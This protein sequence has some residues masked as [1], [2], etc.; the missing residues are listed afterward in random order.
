MLVS[1]RLRPQPVEFS[2]APKLL[3]NNAKSSG[4]KLQPVNK[5][6]MN[7]LEMGA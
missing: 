2:S 4:D 5:H 3:I 1:S 6:L 7:K